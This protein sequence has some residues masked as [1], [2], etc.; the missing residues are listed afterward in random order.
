MTK[1]SQII[2]K[3]PML[4]I[5]LAT[6]NGE[7]HLASL[8]ESFLSQ[9]QP[10]DEVII[11]DDG[12]SDNT[13]KMLNNFKDKYHNLNIKIFQNHSNLGVAKNFSKAIKLCAGDLI[14]LADQDD[15]WEVNKVQVMVSEYIKGTSS[16]IISD[17]KVMDEEGN[18]KSFVFSEYLESEH[19][20]SSSY[21]MNGC[22]VLA[23]KHF[24]LACLPIPFGK[25]HDVWFGYCARRLKTR[26][27]LTKPLMRYRVHSGGLT[28]KGGI[29]IHTIKRNSNNMKRHNN[30]LTLIKSNDSFVL[31]LVKISMHFHFFMVKVKWVLYA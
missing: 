11:C 18:L 19:L 7:K 3:F 17:M 27:F 25:A 6:F 15:V 23:D 4:S 10:V 20:I 21:Y 9:T 24:L 5:A 30:L 26:L 1:K 13:I 31:I 2:P 22:A 29:N 8:L 28:S 14:F 16:Y 12:S